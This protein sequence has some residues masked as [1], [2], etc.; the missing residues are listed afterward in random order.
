MQTQTSTI[1]RGKCRASSSLVRCYDCRNLE[2]S[3]LT[4]SQA[5]RHDVDISR[6][7]L[8][9]IVLMSKM[10]TYFGESGAIRFL[11]PWL[12][13]FRLK[14]STTNCW[15]SRLS[16]YRLQGPLFWFFHEKIYIYIYIY[17]CV[18][19]HIYIHSTWSRFRITP[20]RSLIDRIFNFV[21]TIH[22]VLARRRSSRPRAY[23]TSTNRSLFS[24]RGNIQ[25]DINIYVRI[26]AKA[27][28]RKR[29]IDL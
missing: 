7:Y 10:G 13:W 9:K 8:C 25:I 2:D 15:R 26:S 18:Y 20:T 28:R 21:Y 6:G 12:R 5:T 19:T 22:A 1:R 24:F 14:S 17:K 29:P 23:Y 4:R 11:S 16:R 27:T 3:H